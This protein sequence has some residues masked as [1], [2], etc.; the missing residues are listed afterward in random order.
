MNKRKSLIMG[1][2]TRDII[3]TFSQ[4]YLPIYLAI[5]DTR[6]RYRRSVLGPF[7]ITISTGVMIGTIGIIFGC[8]FN[9]PMN[10]FLPFLTIGLILWFFFSSVITDA[11]TVFVNSEAIIRQ[12]PLPLFTHIVR[13]VSKNFIIFLHNFIIYP[14]VCVCVSKEITWV[15]LIGIPGL[16]VFILNLLWMSLLLGIVCARYRDLSQITSSLLQVIFYV[17][18]IIW[19]PKLLPAKTDLMILDPNP[20]FHLLEIVRSPLLG[21]FPTPMNWSVS[22]LM[23]LF[24]WVVTIAIFDRYRNRVV[25]WL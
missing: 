8:L 10:E 4:A 22:I 16:F 7:W 19:M 20:L 18:P 15:S 25:Y 6:Q 13:M 24:G 3:S 1:A 23:C 21:E 17:T 14:I 12:L 11:S 2:G 5:A 9:S